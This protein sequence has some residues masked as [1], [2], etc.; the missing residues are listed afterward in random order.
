MFQV[1]IM[2]RR[3]IKQGEGLESDRVCVGVIIKGWLRKVY[4]I[5]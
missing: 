2:V 3:T 1:V 5:R 4:L